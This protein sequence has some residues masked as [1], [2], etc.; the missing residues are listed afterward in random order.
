MN[1]KHALLISLLLGV[2]VTAGA[3]A[4]TH[5][6]G[7]Q[8]S[9]KAATAS[10]RVIARQKAKLDRYEASLRTALKKKPPKLPALPVSQ[11]QPSVAA[12]AQRVVYVQ[13]APVIVT[14]HHSGGE[15]DHESE[16]ESDGGGGND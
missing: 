15:A 12:S 13:P 11:A 1:R 4:V 2:A 10:P 7:V 14:T 6:V 16:S 8:K 3:V 9:A 5:T